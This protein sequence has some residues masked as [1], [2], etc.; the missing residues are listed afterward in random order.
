MVHIFKAAPE[1]RASCDEPNC[2]VLSVFAS[3]HRV[4][5]HA[6]HTGHTA[7]YVVETA[8]VYRPAKPEVPR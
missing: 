5:V 4:L 8:T 2:T 6:Q 3:R 7:R 1:A